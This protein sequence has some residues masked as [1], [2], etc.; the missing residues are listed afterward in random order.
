MHGVLLCGL[1]RRQSITKGGN[2]IYKV[3]LATSDNFEII[4]ADSDEEMF[5]EAD[6][7][8]GGYLNIFEVNENY[9]QIRTVI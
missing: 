1:A 6:Q 9:E 5:L 3:E 4:H 8:N 7:T 2:M